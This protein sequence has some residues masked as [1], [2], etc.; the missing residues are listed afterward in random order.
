MQRY[1]VPAA[2]SHDRLVAPTA[3]QGGCRSHG[4]FLL[5]MLG[6]YQAFLKLKLPSCWRHK[7]KAKNERMT[8]ATSRLYMTPFQIDPCWPAFILCSVSTPCCH[9]MRHN[10]TIFNTQTS[11]CGFSLFR[12]SWGG[13][14]MTDSKQSATASL[15]DHRD[16]KCNECLPQITHSKRPLAH[17]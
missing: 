9:T 11:Q 4:G 2:A 10:D 1:M 6:T 15:F 5:G 12:G 8:T 13:W 16:G 3:A 17:S 7:N 14:K